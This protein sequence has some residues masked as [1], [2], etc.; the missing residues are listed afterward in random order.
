M[1]K[2]VSPVPVPDEY[3]LLGSNSRLLSSIAEFLMF[4]PGRLPLTDA[5]AVQDLGI[6]T[7]FAVSLLVFIYFSKFDKINKKK[8]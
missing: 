1:R 4:L 2:F 6:S 7:F 3:H 5:L 8:I